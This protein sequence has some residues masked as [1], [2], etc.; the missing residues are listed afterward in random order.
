MVIFYTLR[1]DVLMY[2]KQIESKMFRALTYIFDK[3]F[4]TDDVY[5]ERYKKY[6]KT[7]YT[8]EYQQN[9]I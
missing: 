9:A 4:I 6:Y 5:N 3:V 1:L 8:K 2:S 7:Y